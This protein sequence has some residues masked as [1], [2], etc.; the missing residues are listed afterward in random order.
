M[1]FSGP[2]HRITLLN[3]FVCE[4][5]PEGTILVTT[6]EDRPGMIG[7][8]GACLGDNQVNIDQFE[9]S[10]TSRGGEAMAM[11]RV[12]DGVSERVLEDHRTRPGITSVRKVVL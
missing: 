7:I 6:N 9:L 8:I 12:E 3:D 4:I 11:I 2:H 10:R 1:V 5:E